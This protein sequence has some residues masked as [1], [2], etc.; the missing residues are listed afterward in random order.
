MGYDRTEVC[1]LDTQEK[2]FDKK[3]YCR[4]AILHLYRPLRRIGKLLSGPDTF[5]QSMGIPTE[6][7]LHH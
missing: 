4:F 6:G 2:F 5:A 1:Y 7:N 3:A